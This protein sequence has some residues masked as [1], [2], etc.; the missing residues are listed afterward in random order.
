MTHPRQKAF[1]NLATGLATMIFE[2]CV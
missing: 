2:K 1:S